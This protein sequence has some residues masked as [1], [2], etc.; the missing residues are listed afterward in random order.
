MEYFF[1][2][3]GFGSES[4]KKADV[5][6][7]ERFHATYKAAPFPH[8]HETLKALH[9]DGVRMGIVTSIIKANVVAA[10]GG[11]NTVSTP[12]AFSQRTA[13]AMYQRAKQLLPL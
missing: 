11:S 4:A 6:Y 12:I 1:L 7:K 2:A 5:R 10:L 9:D 3:V 13:W 8:V